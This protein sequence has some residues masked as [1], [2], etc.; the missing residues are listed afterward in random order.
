MRNFKSLTWVGAARKMIITRG[1]LTWRIE[2]LKEVIK[3]Y[4]YL[5]VYEKAKEIEDEEV[6]NGIKTL[7]AKHEAAVLREKTMSSQKYF[8]HLCQSALRSNET[9]FMEGLNTDIF[10]LSSVCSVTKEVFAD[11]KTNWGRLA[12]A[13]EACT[14]F[15]VHG[16]KKGSWLTNNE[17]DFAIAMIL[18][19]LTWTANEWIRKSP[20]EAM[21]LDVNMEEDD[22]WINLF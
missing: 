21:A 10:T 12:A 22:W 3:S 11:G 19:P 18:L 7:K 16:L 2:N 17:L 6:Q 1:Q 8:N 14:W 5:K 13:T 15:I 20:A 4:V 9:F